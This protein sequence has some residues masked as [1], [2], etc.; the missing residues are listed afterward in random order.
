MFA[1]SASI[2]LTGILLLFLLSASGL[3]S[4]T[5]INADT[6]IIGDHKIALHKTVA[7]Y[8]YHQRCRPQ[9][10]AEYQRPAAHET[11]LKYKCRNYEEFDSFIAEDGSQVLVIKG[12][13]DT[14]Y[15]CGDR[16]LP[17]DNLTDSIRLKNLYE[18]RFTP[19][20]RSLKKNYYICSAKL[21]MI[22]NDTVSDCHFEGSEIDLD[23]AQSREVIKAN[24]FILTDIYYQKGL[25][26]YYLDRSFFITLERK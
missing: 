8:N 17:F 22:K 6:L 14:S 18:N 19:R 13:A 11:I 7:Y 20:L 25:T 24:Q 5:Q 21:Y 10:P 2:K 26:T 16:T 9:L 15:N 3:T 23:V 12:S 4:Q 1:N